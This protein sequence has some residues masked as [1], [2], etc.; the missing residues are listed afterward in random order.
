MDAVVYDIVAVL[1]EHSVLTAKNKKRFLI[2]K[3]SS[4]GAKAWNGNFYIQVYKKILRVLTGL[5]D[6]E[7]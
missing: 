5:P 7:I 3:S 1:K 2:R 4:G 6:W